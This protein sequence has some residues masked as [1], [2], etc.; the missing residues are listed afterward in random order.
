MY[1]IYCDMDEVL[2]GFNDRFQELFGKH[3]K[4]VKDRDVFF[5]MIKDNAE[6]FWLDM[7]WHK[8]GKK[9]WAFIEPYKPTILSSPTGDSYCRPA[10]RG[11]VRENL[12]IEVPVILENRKYIYADPLAILIDDREKNTKAWQENDGIAILHKNANDTIKQLKDILEKDKVRT[13]V[14]EALK[15]IIL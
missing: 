2:V 9:L 13:H 11:W 12:G 5:T 1:K 10:K 14:I 4:D 6:T 3:P 7:P 15:H 8:D